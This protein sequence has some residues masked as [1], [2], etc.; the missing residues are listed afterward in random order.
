MDLKGDKNVGDPTGD[1]N[2]RLLSQKRL[3]IQELC[4]SSLTETRSYRPTQV[5]STETQERLATALRGL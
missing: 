5:P 4:L 2:L 1:T 3:W